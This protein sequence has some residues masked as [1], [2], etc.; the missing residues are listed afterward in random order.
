[1]K[2]QNAKCKIQNAG[3]RSQGSGVR[4]QNLLF[5]LLSSVFCLLFFTG[6][7]SSIQQAKHDEIKG[8][9]AIEKISIVGGGK[10]IL[11]EASGPITYTAFK[12][13]DPARLVLDIPGVDIEKVKAPIEV[14]NEFTN[15]IVVASYGEKGMAPIARVEIGLKERV[16]SDVKMGEGGILVS[17]NHEAVQQAKA[18]AVVEAQVA[19]E[20]EV[21]KKEEPVAAAVE[22]TG[23]VPAEAEKLAPEGLNRGKEIKKADKLLKIETRKEKNRIIIKVIGNGPIGDF[24]SFTMDKPAPSRIVVDVWNVKSSI[25]GDGLT[26]SSPYIKKVRVGEHPDKVRLVFD[27]GRKNAPPYTIERVENSLV[28]TAGSIDA[29]KPEA[30]SAPAARR[31]PG[32][33]SPKPAGTANRRR[34]PRE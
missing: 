30:A 5:C 32:R 24:N 16:A 1:M 18:P 33:S 17:L 21:A 20:Q 14:N 10:E 19:M 3:V 11:V 6:C 25:L 28:I 8:K 22:D 31:C 34:T 4:S 29:K 9:L 23:H 26:V 7:A 15:R 12:L 27:S 13:S 2:M